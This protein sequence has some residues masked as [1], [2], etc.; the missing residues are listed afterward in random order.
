MIQPSSYHSHTTTP[1]RVDAGT[2]ST[3]EEGWTKSQSLLRRRGR[4]G[5]SSRLMST[6]THHE[7]GTSRRMQ[8]FPTNDD[9]RRPSPS[10]PTGVAWLMVSAEKTWQ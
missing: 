3:M 2:A 6:L 8:E 4:G 9:D 1:R 7:D 5:S 10:W